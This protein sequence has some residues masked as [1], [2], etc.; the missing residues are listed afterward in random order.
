MGS[1]QLNYVRAYLHGCQV[2]LYAIV[3]NRKNGSAPPWDLGNIFWRTVTQSRYRWPP[4]ASDRYGGSSSPNQVNGGF[5]PIACCGKSQSWS[6]T[7]RY[8]GAAPSIN[9]P[10]P[11]TSIS[12]A[13]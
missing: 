10:Y 3:L 13:V 11:T 2:Q 8:V 4:D 9:Q 1:T 6:V 7:G 12:E 5:V